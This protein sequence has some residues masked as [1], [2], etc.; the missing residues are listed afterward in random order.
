MSPENGKIKVEYVKYI[1]PGKYIEL[2]PLEEELFSVPD[3]DIHLE[4]VLS[5]HCI[6][7]QNQIFRINTRLK[8]IKKT[9]IK[10]LKKVV[11]INLI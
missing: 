2:E 7:T 9:K 4:R 10:D 6:L 3:Y 1:P 5:D 11:V 8:I